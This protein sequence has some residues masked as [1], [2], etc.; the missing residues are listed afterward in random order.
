[1]DRMPPKVFGEMRQAAIPSASAV[2]LPKLPRIP[3]TLEGVQPESLTILPTYR[4]NAACR[5]CCFESGPGI[6]HRMT[7]D[8]LLGLIRRIPVEL[9]QVKYVVLSG[10]EVTLLKNDLV[11]AIAALTEAGLR[12]RIVT[13]GHWARTDAEAERWVGDLIGAGLNELNLST[14]DE[15]REWVPVESVARAAL[16]ATRRQLL[17]VVTIEGKQ[18]SQLSAEQFQELPQ[19]REILA[20]QSLRK[21]LIT[22]TNVWMPFHQDTGISNPDDVIASGGCENIFSN[23][24]VNPYGNLMS[25][26]GLTMEYIPEMKVGHV[27]GGATLQDVYHGQFDDLL[28]LWIWLDG[29]RLIYDLAARRAG[30]ETPRI[31]PHH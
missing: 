7:R 13:N 1:M 30:L 4:C 9:P 21:W 10:G 22:L 16:Y 24:V 8:E 27:S 23:F 6:K 11:D 25:C 5:E 31:S 20:S 15:H 14:G 12:S 18:N 17:T 26:C 19:V 28:K 29:T 3:G 2:S